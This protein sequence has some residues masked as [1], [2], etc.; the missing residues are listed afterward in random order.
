[1]RSTIGVA[2]L[3][4][5]TV[6]LCS[7][8]PAYAQTAPTSPVYSA[9]QRTFDLNDTNSLVNADEVNLSPFLKWNSRESKLG[10]GLDAAW[11]IT[12][13]QGAFIS[14]EEY[15]NRQSYFSFGYGARTVFKNLEVATFLGTRQNSDDPFGEVELFLRPSVSLRVLDWQDVDVRIGFA[16]DITPRDRPNPM[17]M[18]TVR[19]LKF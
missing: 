8:V 10:G 12:D 11:W 5:A 9:L 6:L 2:V 7:C 14:W 19:A 4:L 16:A 15:S 3:A 1:M 13:Q 18:F 17:L